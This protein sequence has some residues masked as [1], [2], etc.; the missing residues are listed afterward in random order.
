MTPYARH[1]PLSYELELTLSIEIRGEDSN[2]WDRLKAIATRHEREH[3]AMGRRWLRGLPHAYSRT[4]AESARAFA[5]RSCLEAALPV[6]TLHDLEERLT[7]LREDFLTGHAMTKITR[8]AIERAGLADR[9]EDLLAWSKSLPY[10][11]THET[12]EALAVLESRAGALL[13]RAAH[14]RA[15]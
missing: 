4:V 10:Q 8:T 6:W 5:L 14:N 15:A 1:C 2:Q 3:R 9:H 13:A 12:K 7:V 11:L